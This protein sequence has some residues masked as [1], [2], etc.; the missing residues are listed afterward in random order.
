MAPRHRPGQHGG[1]MKVFL[2]CKIPR[3]IKISTSLLHP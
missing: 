1:V 2:N 3:L